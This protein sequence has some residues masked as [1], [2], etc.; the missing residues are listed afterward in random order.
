VPSTPSDVCCTRCRTSAAEPSS[1]RWA[2]STATTTP[3]PSRASCPAAACRT[4][5]LSP[6]PPSCAGT[7]PANAPNGIV[8]VE[9]VARTTTTPD[10]V[11]PA[12]A[13]GSSVRR[14]VHV[15]SRRDLPTP[16]GPASTT[17]PARPPTSAS[18][19]ASSPSRPTSGH[20]SPVS[21]TMHAS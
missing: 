4:A 5:S 13:P 7:Q 11:R 20:P 6:E 3:P 10:P 2:S 18:S 14:A 17:Q 19:I 16:T 21:P 1:S 15:A 12:A 9:R 8:A